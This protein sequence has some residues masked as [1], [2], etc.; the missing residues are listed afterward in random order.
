MKITA[1]ISLSAA[2]LLATSIRGE[3]FHHSDQVV[4]ATQQISGGS[5]APQSLPE[6]VPST[7]NVT[8]VL[9][10][11]EPDDLEMKPD[12][13][14][15]ECIAKVVIHEAGN[16]SYR[17]KLAVAQVII[18]RIN[19]PRFPKTACAVVK[20]RGQFFNVDAY[21]PSRANSAWSEAV[22]IAKKALSGQ[23]DKIVPGALFFH[24]AG[25]SMPGRKLVSRIEDHTFYK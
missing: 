3:A 1:C 11:K 22:A 17:G 19:D 15:L 24:S 12:A 6:E 13:R 16:Q 5:E 21:N 4:G 9:D 20:Q 10:D 8:Q 23:G 14:E 18:N 7:S 25:A 2:L